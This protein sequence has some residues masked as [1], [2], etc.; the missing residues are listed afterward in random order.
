[1]SYHRYTINELFS[2]ADGTIQYIELA[3]GR[4]TG[5]NELAG[6]TIRVTQDG[7]PTHTFGFNRDLP[8][9]ATANT[10]VLLATQ[11]FADLGLV[12][13]DYIIPAGFLF[14]D[15]GTV[16]YA[17]INFL[18]YT[19]LP[20][21]GMHSLTSDLTQL[22]GTPTNFAGQTAEIELVEYNPI[23]GSNAADQL[24]GTAARDRIE[25]LSGNDMLDGAGGDDLLN[26]SDGIDTA[27]YAGNR[28]AYVIG[29]GGL[30]VSGSTTGTD[31]LSGVERLSFND[32]NLA[33]DFGADGAANHTARLLGAVFG[34]NQVSNEVYAGI[35]LGLLDDG[36]SYGDL[37]ELAIHAALGEDIDNADLV[38]LLYTNVV[39]EA[40][41]AATT[42]ALVQ[43]IVDGAFTQGSLTVFAANHPLNAESIDLVGLAETGLAYELY[44][45]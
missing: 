23:I 11:G 43:M 33:F 25:A 32:Q 26:G 37:A 10:K 6:H 22:A 21:D 17:S 9:T 40:P 38:E 29:D 18:S 28:S 30:T 15:G 13:P 39:G 20:T 31:S 34:A 1:M 24:T 2:N 7:E 35:G 27:L 8:S 16:N 12:T 3:C 14:T 36:M 45:A 44:E 41:D 4:F 5:E 42:A 19:S